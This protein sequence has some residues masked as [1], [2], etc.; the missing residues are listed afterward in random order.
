MV[1]ERAPELFSLGHGVRSKKAS[2]RVDMC[3]GW[4]H[5]DTWYFQTLEAGE[6][7]AQGLTPLM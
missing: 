4:H 6:I 2:T 3:R 7:E 1:G 5:E